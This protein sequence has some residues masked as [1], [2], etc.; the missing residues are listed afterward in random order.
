MGVLGPVSFTGLQF[1]GKRG[2]AY[3][4][5]SGIFA[6]TPEVDR[7]RVLFIVHRQPMQNA[8]IKEGRG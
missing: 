1:A 7:I 8:G 6:E 3:Q 2:E 4:F 5:F